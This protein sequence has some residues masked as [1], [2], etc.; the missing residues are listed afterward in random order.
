MA[1]DTKNGAHREEKL[2]PVFPVAQVTR[3]CTRN[4][5]NAGI[6]TREMEKISNNGKKKKKKRECRKA[7]EKERR[8]DGITGRGMC[9]ASYYQ[10]VSQI[11]A[12]FPPRAIRSSSLNE[13]GSAGC[14][15]SYVRQ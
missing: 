15:D 10:T 4:A 7:R 11:S 2:K 9:F 13:P 14:L 3:Y 6:E 8:A 5:R 1:E 12:L